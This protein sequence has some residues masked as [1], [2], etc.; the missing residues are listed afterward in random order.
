MIQLLSY[1]KEQSRNK[2]FTLIELLVVI[3]IIGILSSV[4]IASLTSA[5]EKGDIASIKANLANVRTQAEI[6]RD[7]YGNFDAVC[8][9]SATQ[10]PVIAAA[11]AEVD[12]RNRSGSVVCGDGSSAWA[13]ASDLPGGGAVCVDADGTVKT[14][15]S[16]DDVDD[17]LTDTDDTSCN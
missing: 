10:D 17:A 6:L 14:Y 16:D 5:K 12:T 11:I 7:T 1:M 2:G 13:I 15:D 3:A 8:G 9:I 4:V